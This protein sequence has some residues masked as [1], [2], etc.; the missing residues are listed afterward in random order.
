MILP[1]ILPSLFDS[2]FFFRLHTE[3]GSRG[4]HGGHPTWCHADSSYTE[5]LFYS[6]HK[7][8][9]VSIAINDL[10]LSV[11][12]ISSLDLIPKTLDWHWSKVARNMP[13]PSQ[14]SSSIS[15]PRST[16]LTWN[17]VPASGA[18]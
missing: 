2:F 12:Q 10:D 8:F 7:Y 3:W 11:T 17:Q 9:I 6:I 16:K 4:G 18:G 5:G 14:Q 15:I 13:I 1:L